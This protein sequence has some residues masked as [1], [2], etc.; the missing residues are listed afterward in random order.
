MAR[1][2]SAYLTIRGLNKPLVAN[3]SLVTNFERINEHPAVAI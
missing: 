1:S 2:K 3:Y